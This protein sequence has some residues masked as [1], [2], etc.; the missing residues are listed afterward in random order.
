[1]IK[2]IFIPGSFSPFHDGHYSL[3]K[4]F[5]SEPNTEINIILS[6]KDRDNVN[7]LDVFNFIKYIFKNNNNINVIISNISPIKYIYENTTEDPNTIYY[8]IR[9]SKNS[10]DFIVNEYIKN[11][12]ESGK[13]FNENINVD[14]LNETYNPIKYK[15]IHNNDFIS[16]TLIRD[17]IKN[18]NWKNFKQGYINLLNDNKIS[19]YKLKKFYNKLIN[20]S[21]I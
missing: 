18:K 10:D 5:I 9:S 6:N 19:I 21:N 14:K 15:N 12:S 16:G 20:T 13:F 11:F 17:D 8:M 7:T 1:M 3:V 4:N 2:K